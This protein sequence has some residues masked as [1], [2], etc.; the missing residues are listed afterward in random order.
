MG[1]AD[2]V[3][4]AMAGVGDGLADVA[5]AC[6]PCSDG[7]TADGCASVFLGKTAVSYCREE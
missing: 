5:F 2:R 4:I 1:H 7:E 3:P 6:G